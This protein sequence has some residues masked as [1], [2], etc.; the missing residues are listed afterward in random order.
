MIVSTYNTNPDVNGFLQLQYLPW[1]RPTRRGGGHN[2]DNENSLQGAEQLPGNCFFRAQS[3]PY[4]SRRRRLLCIHKATLKGDPRQL[5]PRRG[6]RAAHLTGAARKAKPTPWRRT[7]GGEGRERD[8]GQRAL[9]DRIQGQIKIRPP[10]AA[11][12][13]RRI[14]AEV[15]RRSSVPVNVA[16]LGEVW[17][18]NLP[19]KNIK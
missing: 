8:A 15:R 6:D 12:H 5:P 4:G 10:I 2:G 16:Y 7:R 11:F 14:A 13:G 17:W 3:A 19:C 9:R 18:Q 1:F